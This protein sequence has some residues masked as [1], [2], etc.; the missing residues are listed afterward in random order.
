MSKRGRWI[1][2][3]VGVVLGV[4]WLGLA[5]SAEPDPDKVREAMERYIKET[6]PPKPKPKPKPEPPK[7]RPQSRPAPVVVPAAPVEQ[8]SRS[9]KDPAMVRIPA[10]C[11][12]MGS[13]V[14]ET[15]REPLEPNEKQHQVCVSAFEMGKHEVTVGEFKRFVEA[16]SHRTDAEQNVGGNGCFALGQDGKAGWQEPPGGVCKLE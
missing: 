2:W 9:S 4:G 5:A 1:G 14:S 11:F 3:A 16:T 12:Q 6:E 15:G 8:P 10:G 13:P 7:P